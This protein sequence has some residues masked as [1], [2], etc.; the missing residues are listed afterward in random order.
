MN[1]YICCPQDSIPKIGL[2]GVNYISLYSSR[3]LANFEVGDVAVSLKQEIRHSGIT[4]TVEAWDFC[5]IA[6]AVAAVDKAAA[7]K[8]SADGWT[9]VLKVEIQLC[10]PL[11]WQKQISI[12]EETLKR[13][14]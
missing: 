6:M 9:R 3:K 8:T 4:P 10:E 11:I 2:K 12:L 7:R 13:Y 1:H 14:R 5:T